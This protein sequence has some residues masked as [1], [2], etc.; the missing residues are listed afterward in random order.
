MKNKPRYIC[1]SLSC[2]FQVFV[3][4]IKFRHTKYSF[5]LTKLENKISKQL[6]KWPPSDDEQATGFWCLSLLLIFTNLK[7]LLFSD[8]ILPLTK[9]ICV[10][11]SICSCRTIFIS[12]YKVSIWILLMLGLFIVSENRE[13]LSFLFIMEFNKTFSK[14][15]MW[16]NHIALLRDYRR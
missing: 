8:L 15:S 1:L 9:K 13:H 11:Q 10:C 14:K 6:A 5:F 2:S 16:L 3:T 12:L 4:I 7:D